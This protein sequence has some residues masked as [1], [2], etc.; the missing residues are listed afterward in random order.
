MGSGDGQAFDFEGNCDNMIMRNCLFHDT[1]GPGFLLCCY[2]SDGHAHSG[3]IMENCVINGKSKRP[4]GLPRCAIVNTTDWNESTWRKCR[5]YLSKGEAVMRVMD[6]EKDK[7]TTF[8]DCRV[9]D[10][11]AACSSK[12]LWSN[13]TA[14]K[15]DVEE[16]WVQLN[17]GKPTTVNE[18]LIKE[19]EGSSISRYV[20]ELWDTK[21][22]TWRSCFNGLSI[23]REFVAPIVERKTTKARLRVIGAKAGQPQIAEFAAFKDPLGEEWNVKRGDNTPNR[24]GKN[25]KEWLASLAVV[26]VAAEESKQVKPVGACLG[27]GRQGAVRETKASRVQGSSGQRGCARF[28]TRGRTTRGNLPRSLPT[29][30]LRKARLPMAVGLRWSGAHG[31]GGTAYPEWVR[32]WNKKGY[33][34]I[35]MD[36]EGH[37]PG[38]KSHQ[39]EG[40]FPTGV[41]HPQAGP[42]RIDWFG[43]RALPDEEQWFYHAVADVIRANSLLRSFPEINPEK[44]GLTGISWGGTVASSVVGGRLAFC[45]CYSGLWRWLYP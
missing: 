10:L 29:M 1:D 31:G 43:D 22:S 3:I 20:I 45:L 13:V 19:Q 24:V 7:K 18:F 25:R 9:K 2:A 42:S 6:P 40:D 44:I 16:Y 17:F 4:I 38:G 21:N 15:G 41:G 8:I 28:F 32:F 23:G 27:L 35:A 30:R 33:A 36:L 37:L 26:P 11:V 14:S 39:L 34:A 5:F 12:K